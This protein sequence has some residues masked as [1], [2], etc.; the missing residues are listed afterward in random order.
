[1][2]HANH[3]VCYT[4][5]SCKIFQIKTLSMSIK[6]LTLFCVFLLYMNDFV[7][8]LALREHRPDFPAELFF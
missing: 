4:L 3:A 2:N 5:S 1:M 8:S 7:N 6:S